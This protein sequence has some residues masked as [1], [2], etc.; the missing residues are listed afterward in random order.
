MKKLLVRILFVIV[1]LVVIGVLGRNFI[2]RKSVEIGVKGVTGFPLEIGA[3]QVGLLSGQLDVR[4]LKLMN[5]PEF[6]DQ[7]FV[8]LP[9]FHVQYELGSLLKGVPH[10]K[11]IVVN[12]QQVVIVKNAKGQSNANA[13]QD[14]LAPTGDTPEKSAQPAV[15]AKKLAYQVDLVRVHI[16]TVVKKDYSKGQPT[17]QTIPFN[18]DI[19]FENISES[20]SI[21]AL[22][23]KVVFGQL[24]DVAGGLIKNAG[25]LSKSL[26]GV[27]KDAAQTLQQ[28]GKGLFDN[29]RK[30]IPQP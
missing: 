27:G 11:E 3:V 24:G 5:P 21:S 22:V 20:T 10:V 23:M 1:T 2:A 7:R 25:E 19:V 18:R 30:A 14:K 16:G 26:G 12:V 13:I 4:N 6:E 17:E 15:P 29:V 9:L 28:T 8:D